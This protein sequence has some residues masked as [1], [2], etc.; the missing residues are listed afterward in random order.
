MGLS[1]DRGQALQVGAILLF[2][3]L[4]V[5]LSLYQATVVPNQNERAEF[6]S[7]LDANS[8]MEQLDSGIG[9]AAARDY[10]TRTAVT[11]GVN[12]PTRTVFVNPGPAGNR[13][14][15][16]GSDTVR[17][18]NA[19]A[20]SGE[21][22]NTRV[23]WNGTTTHEYNTTTVRF[24]SNYNQLQAPSIVYESGVI[25]RPAD[26]TAGAPYGP[27]ES[28]VVSKG[29]TIE[30]NRITIVTLAGELDTGGLQSTVVARPVSAHTRTVV[31]TGNDSGT[32]NITL[33]LPSELNDETWESEVLGDEINDESVLN[34][35]QN[36]TENV[37]VI[38]NGSRTYEL[39]LAKIELRRQADSGVVDEPSSNYI[40]RAAGDNQS[41]NANQSVR[42][43]AEVRDRYN[44]PQSGT[45]VNFSTSD[46]TLEDNSISRTVT[47]D[48]EGRASVQFN[49]TPNETDE[50]TV[51]AKIDGGASAE[52]NT[53][54]FT[55]SVAQGGGGSGGGGDGTASANPSS[56]LASLIWED[57]TSGTQGN[58]QDVSV[59][60]N[61]TASSAVQITGVRYQFYSKDSQGGGGGGPPESV[62]IEDSDGTGETSPINYVGTYVDVES[63][64]DSISS[65]ATPTYTFKFFSG[66]D[67]SGG[68]FDADP[69]DFFLISLQFEL[70]GET[71]T[72]TYFIGISEP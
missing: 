30:G 46:G 36:G 48:S 54:T 34:V 21:A 66:T 29:T 70:N 14:R 3:I 27:N 4:I 62:T 53:T 15:T 57:A 13:L 65:G 45:E 67:E 41:I 9:A 1:D 32:E 23:K 31:V 61:N 43:T 55:V 24:D 11:T 50:R 68:R 56:N 5:G 26:Q 64:L 10:L 72:A 37:D 40:V 49:P 47:T 42:L 6:E 18:E 28:I 58:D 16:S 52:L 17:I 19:E 2:G 20:V 60:F 33:T 51:D 69:D 25:Y 35:T 59:T 39:R 38:L 44:N 12:Y 63:D 8:D 71:E 7:Y 22:A